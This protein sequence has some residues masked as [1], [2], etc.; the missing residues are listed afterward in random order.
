M[1]GGGHVVQMSH[2]GVGSQAI[3]GFPRFQHQ[4]SVQAALLIL[5]DRELLEGRF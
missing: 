2:S 1:T 3:V 4:H 5:A